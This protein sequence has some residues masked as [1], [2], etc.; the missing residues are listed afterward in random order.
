M[1]VVRSYPWAL[2]YSQGSLTVPPTSGLTS[3]I[4]QIRFQESFQQSGRRNNDAK[5]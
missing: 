3:S 2:A 1:E 4:L 5:F